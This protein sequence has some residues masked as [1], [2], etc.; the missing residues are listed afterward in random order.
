[1]ETHKFSEDFGDMVYYH[2]KFQDEGVKYLK[3]IGY[4][5]GDP[6]YHNYF[7]HEDKKRLQIKKDITSIYIRA[8]ADSY[9]VSENFTALLDWKTQ[10]YKRKV[11]QGMRIPNMTIEAMQYAFHYHLSRLGIKILYAFWDPFY[12]VEKGYIVNKDKPFEVIK[13]LVIWPPY[14]FN[15]P[16]VKKMQEQ[17]LINVFGYKIKENFYPKPSGSNVS[18]DPYFLILSEKLEK[19]RNWRDIVRDAK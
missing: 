6:T 1:M 18:K 19:L 10:E 12:N 11:D 2:D 4:T 8:A 7:N 17:T 9:I 3:S 16:E 15:N 13:C 14:S 5:V